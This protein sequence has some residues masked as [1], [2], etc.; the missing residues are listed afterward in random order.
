MSKRKNAA[1]NSIVLDMMKL[2]KC[3]SVKVDELRS[4]LGLIIDDNPSDVASEGI[5]SF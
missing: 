3:M 2:S 5:A 4:D 1:P